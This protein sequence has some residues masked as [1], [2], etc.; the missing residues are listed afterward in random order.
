M[1]KLKVLWRCL[2]VKSVNISNSRVKWCLF[3]TF[4]KEESKNSK[5]KSNS[6]LSI[7]VIAGG[8]GVSQTQRIN[9]TKQLLKWYLEYLN[10]SIYLFICRFTSWVCYCVVK[11]FF[12]THASFSPLCLYVV[13]WSM[14]ASV[15]LILVINSVPGGPS[16]LR[17]WQP[18]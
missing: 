16:L 14:S 6:L 13:C 4:L 18:V 1:L 7:S 11:V 17:C 12:V 3:V 9:R 2:P 15:S 8:G 5:S 10:V